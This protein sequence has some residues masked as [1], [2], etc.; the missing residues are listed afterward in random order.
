[1]D[2]EIK[3]DVQLAQEYWKT[4]GPGLTTGASDDDPSGIATYSQA[5]AQYGFSTLWLAV[6]TLPLMIVVQEMCA[7]IGLV[8]GKGLAANIK[9]FLPRWVLVASTILLL[10]A[11]IMNLGA[12]LG[13]MSTALTLLFPK[14]NFVMSLILFA[15]VSLS[16]QIFLNY[17]TYAKYL[18]WLTFA[19]LSYAISALSIKLPWREMLTHSFIPELSFTKEGMFLLCAFLGT[20]ISPFLFFWQT[21]QEVE[22]Q[23][24]NNQ[25]KTV[26]VK[27]EIRK[28][29]ID[30]TS[31][32]FFSN[33][34]TFF[35]ISACAGTLYAAGIT[36]INTAADAALALR[37]FAGDFAFV[38]FAV[39]IIGTGLL[40]IPI[41]AGSA[42]YALSETFGWKAG[43]NRKYKNAP[44]FYGVIVIAV[45]IGFLINLVGIDPIDALLWAAV[46]NGII[47]PII[48]TIIIVIA[49]KKEIM[50]QAI[51]TKIQNVLGW[52]TVFVMSL[53]AILAIYYLMI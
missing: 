10:I 46:I 36:N 25:S 41:M 17:R 18:K 6:Y 38:L 30:V 53:V 20:T 48:I 29:R 3:K 39:G 28:M 50:G 35:I 51:N 12:D 5:G 2:E 52:L 33:L 19:L 8:T 16:L 7:R 49:S 4:L 26:G 32:M 45:V 9:R 44:H 11:N 22:E 21:S 31:G 40:A 37:P 13:A 42:A 23:K 15:G 47:A 27:E 34:A 24:D 43:L 14:F 1:M